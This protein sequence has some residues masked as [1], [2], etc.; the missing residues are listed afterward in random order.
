MRLSNL[1]EKP[2]ILRARLTAPDFELEALECDS[3]RVDAATAFYAVQGLHE[4]GHAFL[5]AALAAGAP[6]V[7]VSDPGVF[8]ELAARSPEGPAGCPSG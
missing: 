8:A 2:V 3:R 5:P 7:F 4:D 6:A 1:A